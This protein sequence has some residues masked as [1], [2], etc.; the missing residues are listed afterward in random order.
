[1]VKK[2]E[3]K[4]FK[5]LGVPYV[6]CTTSGSMAMLMALMAYDIKR[7]DE[8]IV[9]NR[10]WISTAHAP[11]LLGVKVKAVDVKKNIPI[12]DESKIIDKISKKTKAIIPVYMGG[13]YVDFSKIKKIAKRYKLKIIEDVAQGL[14]GKNYNKFIGTDGD[15]G[16]F[17]LSVAKIISTGQGGFLLL[18]TKKYEK[19]LA[20]RT[21]GVENAINVQK[22]WPMPGFNFRFNDILLLLGSNNW[23]L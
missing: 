18:K 16:C 1:M 19:L 5:I 10:T 21:H 23:R 4:N 13:R 8:V 9:P 14:F 17:S 2:F 15:I 11:H 3:E 12:I 6:V 20:I 22:N 7:G